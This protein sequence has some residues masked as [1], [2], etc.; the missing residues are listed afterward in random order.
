MAANV[1]QGRSSATL[2][3]SLRRLRDHAR[4]QR[5]FGIQL[6]PAAA[7][8]FRKWR[9][10]ESTEFLALNSARHPFAALRSLAG[11]FGF[12]KKTPSLLHITHAKAG[13]TWV[14]G[15]LR[16]LFGKRVVPRSY[17]APD[18]AKHRGSV[19]SIFMSRDEFL[20]HPE[21]ADSKRFVVLRDLRDTLISRYFSIRD[22]H[23]P[24]PGGKIEAARAELRA[25]SVEDGL[26]RVMEDKGMAVTAKIQR[27]WLGSGEIVLRYEDLIA[28]DLPLF[29]KLFNEQLGLGLKAADLESAVTANRFET[30]FQRKLGE[31]DVKSHGRKGTPGD[32]RNHFTPA[33]TAKFQ[34]LYGDL[35]PADAWSAS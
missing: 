12:L 11:M 29:T 14:E 2:D 32:W 7:A 30:V 22:S 35:L 21:L 8:D 28:N 34:G 9:R 3:A 24:D 27:S 23:E 10:A 15:I 4:N 16:A 6:T 17:Q 19:F 18:F 5:R 1:I 20:A 13:S 33:L 31:E 26:A 25:M